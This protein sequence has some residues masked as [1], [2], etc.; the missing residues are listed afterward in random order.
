MALGLSV[1]FADAIF[2]FRHPAELGRA[3]F[4]IYMAAPVLAVILVL[5]V[6]EPIFELRLHIAIGFVS[7][8]VVVS[9]VGPLLVG[10]TVRAI[11]PELARHIAKPVNQLAYGLLI[12]SLLP[13]LFRSAPTL[14]SLIGNGNP[15]ESGRVCPGC[16]RIE[17]LARSPTAREPPVLALAS[18]SRHPAIAMVIAHANFP[19]EKYVLASVLLYMRVSGI[20]TSVALKRIRQELLRRFLGGEWPRNPLF[21]GGG[22]VRACRSSTRCSPPK[23][24][25]PRTFAVHLT[26]TEDGCYALF[27]RLLGGR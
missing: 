21:K 11:A 1:N 22:A 26:Q 19:Q 12:L 8:L 14:W 27:A 10:I 17:F 3:F 24:R 23:S 15:P 25:W 2:L 18:A 4:S 7:R 6:F 5:E 16:Y 13:V 20:V 9:V